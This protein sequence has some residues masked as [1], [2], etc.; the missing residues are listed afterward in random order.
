MHQWIPDIAKIL[1]CLYEWKIINRPRVTNISPKIIQLNLQ[2][3]RLLKTVY[4]SW[5]KTVCTN[6]KQ[7]FN[8]FIQKLLW[9]LTVSK[10]SNETN[11]SRQLLKLIQMGKLYGLSTRNLAGFKY[12]Y[13]LRSSFRSLQWYFTY[14]LMTFS[15]FFF[16]TLS[17]IYN[18]QNFSYWYII[19]YKIIR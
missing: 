18:L 19:K 14:F 5:I 10:T 13:H 16:Q 9:Y 17:L 8:T 3:D 11:T 1:K 4:S 12:F 7:M 2:Y 15:H 6:K